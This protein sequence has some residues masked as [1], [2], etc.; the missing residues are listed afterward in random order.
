MYFR[1]N[2]DIATLSCAL[3][4]A[5][6]FR[7]SSGACLQNQTELSIIVNPNDTSGISV[8]DAS[9]SFRG[10]NV[11]WPQ[12]F[13]DDGTEFIYQND[14][15]WTPSNMDKSVVCVP[16][17]TDDC[18]GLQLSFYRRGL[19]DGENPAVATPES[20]IVTYDGEEVPLRG[21]YL[22]VGRDS[23]TL[24]AELGACA[25]VTCGAGAALFEMEGNS[26][27]CIDWWVLDQKTGERVLDCPNEVTTYTNDGE[28]LVRDGGPCDWAFSQDT[29]KN[30][31]VCLPTN[32]CYT[33]GELYVWMNTSLHLFTYYHVLSCN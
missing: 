31:R 12:L 10:S 25:D 6:W 28:T 3:L 15:T 4:V 18:Y 27:T 2:I 5:S 11:S 33:F 26:Q 14:P 21:P 9:I 29:V 1:S 20:F 32:N 7:V 22:Y 23:E 13:Y 16:T 24:V 19:Y 30:T 17:K 8:S